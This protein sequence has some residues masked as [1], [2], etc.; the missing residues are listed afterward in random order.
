MGKITLITGGQR[1]GKSRYAKQMAQELSNH[2]VY[3]ATSRKWDEDHEKRIKKHQEDR[4]NQWTTIEE[5][6]YISK[7]EWHGKTVL[8]DCVTLWLTNFF[9]DNNNDI[10]YSLEQAKKELKAIVKQD[11]HFIIVSNEL[12]MGGHPENQIQMKFN[13]LQGWTNQFIA[14]MAEE[15]YLMVSGIPMKIKG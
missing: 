2:P 12:G 6:K 7:Y 1:S 3:L 5:E 13:D 10:E 11:T 8:M 9:Y 15:V 4:S 14:E